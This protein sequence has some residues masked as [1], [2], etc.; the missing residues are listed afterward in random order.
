MNRKEKLTEILNSYKVA[1]LRDLA[2]TTGLK[3]YSKLKKAE[4][5]DV[6]LEQLLSI[7]YDT[8]ELPEEIKTVLS[9]NEDTAKKPI[10]DNSE[11]V[12]NAPKKQE[13]AGSNKKIAIKSHIFG[14]A[15][16]VANVMNDNGQ[17]PFIDQQQAAQIAS[18]KVYPNDPCPC[19][20]G[21]KYKK[22]CGRR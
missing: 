4:L 15:P 21:K 10:E 2:K 1:D 17:M 8:I 18:K 22:C 19:G 9:S 6:V 5:I 12:N 3:G 7:E 20:S 14:V 11:P 13:T 16:H